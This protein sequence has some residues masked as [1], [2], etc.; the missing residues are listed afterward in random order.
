MSQDHKQPS[1]AS[2]PEKGK[3]FLAGPIDAAWLRTA[4]QI[5]SAAAIASIPLW[6][7]VGVT[8]DK[9]FKNHLEQSRFFKVNRGLREQFGVKQ[10]TMTRGLHAL[11][12]HGLIKIEKGGRGRCPVVAIINIQ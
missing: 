7:K 2:G 6:F 11:E 1:P 5:S 3:G 12:E 9:F 10:H 4:I 8:R